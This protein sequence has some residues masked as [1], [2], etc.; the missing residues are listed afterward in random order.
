MKKKLVVYDFDKTIYDGETGVN[1]SV[2]YLKK[3][4]LKS[5]LFLITYSRYL[6]LYLFKIV[7][8]SKIK[9]KY[10]KFLESHTKR[11]YRI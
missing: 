8:L 11:K 4:P 2:F 9:E 10:F 7:N 1:F 5:I 3:Y 6:F